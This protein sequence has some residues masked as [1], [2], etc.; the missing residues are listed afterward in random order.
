MGLYKI[1]EPEMNIIMAGEK[2][3]LTL[4]DVEKFLHV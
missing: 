1:V 2:Y 3:D 4:D